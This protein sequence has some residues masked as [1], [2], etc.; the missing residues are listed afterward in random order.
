MLHVLLICP[1]WPPALGGAGVMGRGLMRALRARGRVRVT[2]LVGGNGR[3]AGVIG[4]GGTNGGPHRWYS[5]I[6]FCWRAFWAARRICRHQKVDVVQAISGLP[7]G[8]VAAMLGRP[9]VV[10][11]VG[12]DVPGHNPCYRLFDRLISGWLSPLVW[13][14]AARVVANSQELLALA[15]RACPAGAHIECIA[16]GVDLPPQSAEKRPSEALR[17]GFVGRLARVKN[18][19]LLLRACAHLGGNW[20]LKL[21]GDGPERD[22]LEQLASELGIQKRVHFLGARNAAGV[23]RQLQQMDIFVLPSLAEGMSNAALEAAAAGLPLLLGPVGGADQLVAEGKN[24]FF[25]SVTDESDLAR[26]LEYFQFNTKIIQ[27]MGARSRQTAKEFSWERAAKHYERCL[28][29]AAKQG[30]S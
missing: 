6:F 1:E 17:I 24:G 23:Q 26:R 2:A 20:Q 11:L 7:S 29:A 19:P 27:K 4:V 3:G 15:R 12:S 25:I 16:G 22:Y 28:I 9:F 21:V 5:L 10:S 8:L 13:R 18:L 14:R 30:N